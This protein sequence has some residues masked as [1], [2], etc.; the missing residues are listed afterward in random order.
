MCKVKKSISPDYVN[1]I[2]EVT[3][4]GYSLRNV[5]FDRPWYNTVYYG[6]HSLRYFGPYLWSKLTQEERDK[7]SLECFKKCARQKNLENLL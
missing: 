2:F 4:K 5:D 7:A 6:K 1:R 3:D